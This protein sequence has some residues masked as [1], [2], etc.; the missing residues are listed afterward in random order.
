MLRDATGIVV[1]HRASTV[2]LADKVALL[3][4]GTITHVG[5]HHELLATVPEYR[6]LLASDAEERRCAERGAAE[7]SAV[8]AMRTDQNAE[9]SDRDEADAAAAGPSRAGLARRRRR[10]HTT[11]SAEQASLLL[12]EPL[13]AAARRPAPPAPKLIVWLIAIVVIENAAAARDPLPGQGRHRLAA[14]RRCSRGEGA[15]HAD[16]GRRRSSW[17]AR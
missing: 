5:T 13:P 16:H 15:D 3:Q 14:S 6:D 8:D 11:R 7:T 2:L 17:S 12:R 9:D 1:A 4:D 10:G